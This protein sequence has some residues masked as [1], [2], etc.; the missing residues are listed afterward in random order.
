MSARISS[1]R[2]RA[3]LLIAVTCSCLIFALVD[4]FHFIHS[5]SISSAAP[6]TRPELVLQNGH[7]DGI[8]AAAVSPDGK[9]A[10]TGSVDQLVNIWETESG[11]ELRSLQGHSGPIWALAISP[12]GKVLASAGNDH[13]VRLWNVGT[14]A[15]I[16]RFSVSDDLIKVLA[17]NPDGQKLAAGGSSSTVIVWDLGSNSESVRFTDLVGT[18]TALAFSGD[19]QFLASGSA[20]RFLRIWDLTKRKKFKELAGF[21]DTIQALQFSSDGGSVASASAD[22][23]VRIWKYTTGQPALEFKEQTAPVLALTFLKDGRLTTADASRS[24]TTWDVAAGK[25]IK[26]VTV[27]ANATRATVAAFSGDGR[28][29]VT[30]NG[31]RTAIVVSTDTGGELARLENR[32]VGFSGVAFSNDSKWLAS[33]GNDNSVRLWDLKT[34]QALKAM[35]GH[36]GYV[37]SVVFHPDNRRLISASVDSTIIVWD[38]LSRKPLA[39]LKGHS[40]Q[41]TSLA[42]G[43]TGKLVASGSLDR[44][45]RLWELSRPGASTPLMGHTREV[46]AVALSPDEKMVVSGSSDKTIRLW[47]TASGSPIRTIEHPAGPVTSLAFSRDGKQ[48]ASGGADGT[49]RIWDE[50]SGKLLKELP[51]RAGQVTS[52]SF[53]PDRGRISAGGE[54]KEVRIWDAEGNGELQIL[55]GHYG[56]ISSMAYSSDARWLATASDDGC[57]NL[58]DT[59]TGMRTVSLLSLREGNDWL[60]VSPEGFF[61][62]SPN[63]WNKLLWRFGGDSFSVN[64]VEIFFGEFY[65]P[66]LVSKLLSGIPLPADR[67]ISTKDRRQ[68]KLRISLV[69]ENSRART[70]ADRFVTVRINV[71]EAPPDANLKNGSGAKDVRLFRNGSLVRFWENDKLG[72]NSSTQLEATIPIV[73]GPNVLTAYAFNNDDIKS[74]DETLTVQG[75]E[76]LARMGKT[77]IVSFGVGRYEN[78]SFDL[79]YVAS[80]A[81]S[82]GQ[83]LKAKLEDSGQNTKVDVITLL[84]QRA[85]KENILKT[86]K[87]MSASDALQPEDSVIVYFSGHGISKGER[88]FM[89]PHDIGYRGPIDDLDANGIATIMQHGISD[90]ELE[91][92]FRG[93]DA[94][95]VIL[96]VDACESGQALL[97]ADER[98]GPMNSKGLAQFAYEKGMYILTATQGAEEAFVSKNLQRSYL[99]YAL[100]DEA[101]NDD[102]AD[103]DPADGVVMLREWFD[104]ATA[105]VP[106]LQAETLGA[107]KLKEVAKREEL[108]KG[109]KVVAVK[110]EE[111][112]PRAFYRRQEDPQQM[113]ISRYRARTGSP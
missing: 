99:N 28:V 69:G 75:A 13:T 16:A 87:G 32:T 89:I 18:V 29:L 111:Q 45:V 90:R 60:A 61:D 62:G 5:S 93:I 11:R 53:S 112:R 15:E 73:A 78:P 97:S 33:A 36:I 83:M 66:G 7:S 30:G 107:A 109:V 46:T 98:Q 49:L 2:P 14:G 82:F 41:V 80:D 26:T 17:F 22:K 47:D 35:R 91:A 110:L 50:A 85:T 106:I 38:V 56:S 70:I 103:T 24:V 104:Y 27:P 77:Y 71:A 55:K 68:P 64:P 39:T 43:P 9:W 44:T 20:D 6:T 63:S 65:Q 101:L 34:G 10:A 19:G 48:V 108:G 88:F 54:D 21:V 52:V 79:D 59:K 4:N 72:T 23:S 92:A 86:L 3:P 100:T 74:V 8:L 40:D 42:L 96:I 94:K 37:T 84:D 57:I 81:T 76:S 105:R 102:K 51:R 31:G 113:V 12:D 1:I 67:D 25:S 58:W 95:N